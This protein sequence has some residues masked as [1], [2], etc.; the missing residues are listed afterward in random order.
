[1][2]A[3]GPTGPQTT[4]RRV[5][6]SAGH[7]RRIASSY[8]ELWRPDAAFVGDTAAA[9]A[10]ALD[11]RP[12]DRLVDHG[13]GTG[14]HAADLAARV[15]LLTPPL[16]VDPSAELLAQA[17]V[18]V[19][20]TLVADAAEFAAR[21]RPFDK[22]MLKEMLHHLEPSERGE[23]LALLAAATPP[24][25]RMLAVLLPP[26][27]DHPL[28]DAAMQRFEAAQPRYDDVA[29]ALRE[30]GLAVEVE[31]VDRPLAVDRERY[32]EMLRG[33]YMSLLSGFGDDELEAGVNEMLARHPEPVLCFTY[34]LAFVTG[35]RP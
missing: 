30:G 3:G 1:M 9:V 28:F 27:I 25:G 20:E 12:G 19:V 22:L 13:G 8:D 17:P 11:L 31:M 14:M 32:A 4:L 26:R 35:S 33:R 34:R 21:P 7:Y 15:G 29:A 6:D 18:G 5:S 10:R 23:V 24:G 2:S 16:V